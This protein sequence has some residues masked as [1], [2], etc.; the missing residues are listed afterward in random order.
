LG[1]FFCHLFLGI[2]LKRASKYK[3]RLSSVSFGELVEYMI[4]RFLPAQ[5]STKVGFL[6]INSDLSAVIMGF[7]NSPL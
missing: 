7:P 3:K 6:K 2:R 1:F 5:D 4:S